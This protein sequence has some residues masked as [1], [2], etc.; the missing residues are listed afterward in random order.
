MSDFRVSTLDPGPQISPIQLSEGF[1]LHGQ[2]EATLVI[3]LFANAPAGGFTIPK[4][5]YLIEDH[6]GLATSAQL[7]HDV[8]F[9]AGTNPNTDLASP[10][11]S[12]WR[13]RRWFSFHLSRRC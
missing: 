13:F 12:K 4:D 9:A 3:K 1:S 2:V 6:H 7:L 8:V 11:Y 5:A 10:Q